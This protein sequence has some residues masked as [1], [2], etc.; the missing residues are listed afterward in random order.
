MHLIIFKTSVATQKQVGK[1][2]S[3]LNALPLITEC[4]FDLDDCDNILR[5]ISTDLQPQVI[6]QLLRTEGFGCET[7][8]S[9]IYDQ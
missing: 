4:N 3:L 1:L 9:F 6:C 8:E 2:Q 7:M 5:V